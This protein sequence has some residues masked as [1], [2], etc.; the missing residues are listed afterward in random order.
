MANDFIFAE[1]NDQEE[2]PDHTTEAGWKVLIVDDEREVH[3][4]TRLALMDLVFEGKGLNFLSAYS[5]REAE[6]L[7]SEHDDIAIVLLD[8]VMDTDDA[9]LQVAKYI[10]ETV[11]NRT[12]RIVLRTGQ[13]GQAPERSVVIN[14]D[15]NDY[16]AKTELTAQKLF[17]CV[18]SALRSYRDIIRVKEQ[19]ER[20]EHELSFYQNWLLEHQP[21]VRQQV[22]DAYQRLT[23]NND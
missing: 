2:V 5:R 12:S 10:R 4:V 16:K 22:A 8:V 20:V 3:A 17:T 1:E 11:D 7:I 23:E 6:Q 9:G 19:L 14:Y 18:M 13:P 15:I 21:Q